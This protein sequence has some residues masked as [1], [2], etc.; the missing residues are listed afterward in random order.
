MRRQAEKA[1][2]GDAEDR[3]TQLKHA[4]KVA[5]QALRT[6][7][8]FQNDL[9]HSLRECGLIAALRGHTQ[10]ARQYLDESL[11]VADRQRA[12]YEHAQTLLARGQVGQQHGWP[13]AQQDLTS[14]RQALHALGADF[15]LDAA[16]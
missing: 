7:C 3:P 9:P 11:A 12:R 14:A 8:K 4:M 16:S 2:D 6:A 10:K 13:E 1:T 15:A 5:Q